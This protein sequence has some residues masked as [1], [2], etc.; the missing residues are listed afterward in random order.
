MASIIDIQSEQ[1]LNVDNHTREIQFILFTL[2][3]SAV[4]DLTQRLP[5][6]CV[7]EILLWTRDDSPEGEKV[8]VVV[9][10][11]AVCSR[12]R[13]IALQ[14]SRLWS[15][16]DVPHI[17]GVETCLSRTSQAPLSLFFSPLSPA[18]V[19]FASRIIHRTRS[20]IVKHNNKINIIGTLEGS[21]AE[22]LEVMQIFSCSLQD[23]LFA[24]GP[25]PLQRLRLT[26]CNFTWGAP[27]FPHTLV[28]LHISRP[29]ALV[30]VHK[31]LDILAGTP[32]LERL[33]LHNVLEPS[34]D[35]SS[36]R[37]PILSSLTRASLNEPCCT[38]L[39]QLFAASHLGTASSVICEM[40]N[41]HNA[42]L[43]V[44]SLSHCLGGVA[45]Y[46]L[47]VHL[48]YL[49]TS[50]RSC[51]AVATRRPRRMVTV[52]IDHGARAG[53]I[54]HSLNIFSLQ[55]LHHFAFAFVTDDIDT[56]WIYTLGD[57]PKLRTL[58]LGNAAALDFIQSLPLLS[59]Q[60]PALR[61]LQFNVEIGYE[62]DIVEFEVD[63]DVVQESLIEMELQ[64]VSF[65][66]E[67]WEI[68]DVDWQELTDTGC[69]V[70][71]NDWTAFGNE[72]R[73]K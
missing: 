36:T 4:E 48:P 51:L 45:P 42:D 59:V 26:R 12:W 50:G 37:T 1:P 35:V 13:S 55:N 49:R 23:D 47:R 8:L 72:L 40:N 57:L 68:A 31:L 66:G 29:G 7:A 11:T 62:H 6:E 27:I 67:M 19:S 39:I 21:K 15:V 30:P 53:L 20:L 5:A 52:L 44:R 17:S 9:K 63:W 2:A 43:L 54:L 60:F 16:I 58:E 14:D 33:Y 46:S 3:H 10:L 65:T 28:S 71:L 38:P 70:I 25:P 61:W 64:E 32:S 22:L 56:E 73:F 18:L 41:L 69:Q 34:W 24:Q